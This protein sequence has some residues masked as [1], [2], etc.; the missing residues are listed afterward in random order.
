MMMNPSVDTVLHKEE[1][2]LVLGKYEDLHKLFR[3]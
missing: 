3:T 2:M 1:T